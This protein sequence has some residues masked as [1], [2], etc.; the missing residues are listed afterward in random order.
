[1]PNHGHHPRP[2]QLNSSTSD[3]A[4]HSPRNPSTGKATLPHARTRHPTPCSNAHLL[5]IG[6]VI[7]LKP[8]RPS[9]SSAPA[10]DDRRP[11]L[12]GP[13]P[14]KGDNGVLLCSWRTWGGPC[15][16]CIHRSRRTR[17]LPHDGLATPPG[18]MRE[19]GRARET[20]PQ[21]A[22]RPEGPAS[23]VPQD[24]RTRIS[25]RQPSDRCAASAQARIPGPHAC[26][27][28]G[29]VP[30]ASSGRS[31]FRGSVPPNRRSSGPQARTGGW[32]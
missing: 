20:R 13:G 26:P 19:P 18:F 17:K 1:M 14:R 22:Q 4:A 31:H 15:S 7:W 11:V 3:Q 9:T 6:G 24:D 10:V 21:A 28:A 27:T 29:G 2:D 16:E 23:P 12:R 8:R 32:P 25:R 5:P 30:P